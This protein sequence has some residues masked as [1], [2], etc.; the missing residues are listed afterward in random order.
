MDDLDEVRAALGYPTLDLYGGSYGATAVQYYVLRHGD[1]ARTAILDGGTLLDVPIFERYAAAGQSALDTLFARCAAQKACHKAFPS[2]A[3]DLRTLL[4]RVDRKPL[5]LKGMTVG[6]DDLAEAVQ[7]LSRE[8]ET[9]ALIPLL[10]RMAVRDGLAKVVTAMRERVPPPP[11]EE[12]PQVMFWAIT[13]LEPWARRDV[14]E[15]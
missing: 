12:R 9:A 10:L 11:S 1:T 15:T 13:C 7:S 3:R 5:R 2:P 6:R 14:A 4:G 8:P